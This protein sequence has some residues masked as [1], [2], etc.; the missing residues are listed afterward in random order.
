MLATSTDQHQ[1]PNSFS[2]YTD[3]VYFII[4]NSAS[5]GICNIKSMFVVDF[6]QQIVTL[7]TAEGRPTT[8]KQVGTIRLV[9][10]MKQTKFGHMTLLMLTMIQNCHIAY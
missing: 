10:K 2:V 8:L 6:E 5:G 3:G 7:V 4:D 1:N 9:L